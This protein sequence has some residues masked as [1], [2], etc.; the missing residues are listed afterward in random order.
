MVVSSWRISV[1]GVRGVLVGVGPCQEALAGAVTEDRVVTVTEGFGWGSWVLGSVREAVAGVLSRH[2]ENVEEIR[3]GVDAGVLGVSNAT[4]A[5][6]EGQEDMAAVF[7]QEMLE[8]AVDGD[9]SVFMEHGYDRA[10]G[11][12]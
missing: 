12:A 1:D 9:M 4:L 6:V 11:G 7:Q 5:Y 10:G 2:V 3:R 8:A